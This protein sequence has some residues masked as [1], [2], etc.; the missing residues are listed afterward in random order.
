MSENTIDGYTNSYGYKSGG[1]NG[2]F[3]KYRYGNRTL[4]KCESCGK[5]KP[6]WNNTDGIKCKECSQ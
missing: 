4:A 6:V 3:N 5:T 2:Y 1:K